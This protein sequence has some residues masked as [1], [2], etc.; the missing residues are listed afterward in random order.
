MTT[1]KITK[2]QRQSKYLFCIS[3]LLS[4]VT[5]SCAQNDENW[6]IHQMNSPPLNEIE[7][8]ADKPTIS[9]ATYYSNTASTLKAS[10]YDRMLFIVAGTCTGTV[11]SE[12]LGLKTGDVLFL[13][14]ND[15]LKFSANVRMM[16]WTSKSSK[17]YHKSK[18]KKFT[19]AEIESERDSSENV[20]NSFIETST[21]VAGLY[22]LPK[23][24]DGDDTLTHRFDEINYVVSGSA[25]FKMNNTVID[26]RPGSIMW[27]KRGVGH[28]F[29]NLSDDFDVFILFETINMNHDY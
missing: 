25:K 29:Y 5:S 27:V 23:S 9:G 3:C 2:N 16:I 6:F 22:M 15:T 26:V 4:I 19:K 21:M 24:L 20:W 18:T 13:K 14:A 7:L 8:Y 11:N 17:I 10:K 28:N 12:T 1:L